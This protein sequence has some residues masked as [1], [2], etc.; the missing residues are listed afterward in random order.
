V[1]S[2]DVDLTRTLGGELERSAAADPDRVLVRFA[3]G[4]VTPGGL[5]AR[6]RSVAGALQAWGVERGDR[7]AVMM[8]NVGEFLDAWFGIVRLG[9]VEVPVHSAYKGPLLSHVLTQSG[10]S[11]LFC[12]AE[13]VDRL[14]ELDLPNLERVIVRGDADP[15]PGVTM[16]RFADVLAAAAEPRLPALSGED[17]SCILYT[18][19]TTGP[20][21]GVVLTHSANL[22][23]AES[24]IE[25]VGWTAEDTLYTAFPLFHVNAKFT[26][27]MPAMCSGARL[28]MDR[29]FSASQ[30]WDRMREEGVTGFNAMGAMISMIC[31][32]PERA[33]DRDHRVR[34]TYSAATPRAL[35]KPFEARF[36][37]EVLEHYGMTEVGIAVWNREGRVGSCGR[38]APWFTVRLADE[39]DR[40]VEP[41]E[42]G[43]IQIRPNLPGIMP[44]EYWQRPDANREAFR[45]LWFHTGD[46]ARADADGFLYYLDRTKDC[47][48]RRGENVSSWELESVVNAFEDVL[49]S[50]AYGVP[51]EL[52]EE[53]VMVAVVV[54]PG[55]SLDLDGLLAYCE[56]HLARFA[57]PRYVRVVDEL[58]KTPSQRV[59]KFALRAAGVTPDTVDRTAPPAV[60][61]AK[62]VRFR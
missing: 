4:D 42:G 27:V 55:R 31:A 2:L 13:F 8:D 58:P 60:S 33:S 24:A 19:G 16:E 10:S 29:R 9:A 56:E 30:F 51:S 44:L 32:Q 39:H 41:G 38:P 34:R 35:W 26:S 48:R 6:S 3:E 40:E 50:A 7:V 12:E 59:Q 62:C 52:G 54:A 14:R 45:N 25:F 53:D 47:I 5:E 36:G 49:E 61:S 15:L 43:E 1:A 20:S 46:R 37:V 23:L 11:T 57:V 18:S 21:K 28:V 17:V 22:H